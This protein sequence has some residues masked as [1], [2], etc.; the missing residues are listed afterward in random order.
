M[1]DGRWLW[2]WLPVVV[3][4][5]A[6]LFGFES[7]WRRAGPLELVGEVPAR[8]LSRSATAAAMAAAGVECELTGVAPVRALG[9]VAT[10]AA[11]EAVKG[12]F[13]LAGVEPARALGRAATAVVLGPAARSG[14]LAGVVP[15]R[16]LRGRTIFW[17]HPPG[18]VLEVG[19]AAG[20][21]SRCRCSV[22]GRAVGGCGTEQ[23]RCQST[24]EGEVQ[25]R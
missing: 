17:S 15:A 13:E 4:V 6:L 24:S 19:A 14:E 12:R 18:R 21:S 8:A 16:A 10:A 2:L 3:V 20:G 7:R 5:G 23:Q 22:S 25:S 11:T 9:R 1:A